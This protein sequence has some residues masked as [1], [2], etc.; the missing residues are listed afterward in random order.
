MQKYLSNVILLVLSFILAGA[1]FYAFSLYG[2]RLA[3]EGM[4]VS[5]ENTKTA[6]PENPTQPD[7][8]KAWDQLI[9]KPLPFAT[10]SDRQNG[11]FPAGSFS[12]T[13]T[14]RPA[15]RADPTAKER[16]PMIEQD[17]ISFDC[18][19]IPAVKTAS[20]LRAYRGGLI[21]INE[22]EEN[23]DKIAA[24]ALD[25]TISCPKPGGAPGIVVSSTLRLA[26]YEPIALSLD[27]QVIGKS[28]HLREASVS[29][30]PSAAKALVFNGLE[31]RQTGLKYGTTV[32]ADVE[33]S[34]PGVASFKLADANE[35]TARESA[36][37]V[38]NAQWMDFPMLL[39]NRKFV[40]AIE[41]PVPRTLVPE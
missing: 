32:G 34:K 16:A 30:G 38:L 4:T 5:G 10:R 14:P 21:E 22:K 31:F 33:I 28:A 11:E 7:N 24:V 15:L 27:Y 19:A 36:L 41:L 25:W 13:A 6:G 20:L 18:S 23:A 29:F 17:I 26:G 37:V 2:K 9:L 40:L 35:P 8:P 3:P 12:G 39:N 1:G